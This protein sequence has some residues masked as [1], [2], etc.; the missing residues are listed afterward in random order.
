[1]FLHLLYVNAFSASD[2]GLGAAL[3]QVCVRLACR[4]AHPEVVSS[5]VTTYGHLLC[6]STGTDGPRCR[7]PM[8]MDTLGLQLYLHASEACAPRCAVGLRVA[9]QNTPS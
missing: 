8:P 4:I 1:M 2:I 7:T 9:V 5:S 6:G 3:G